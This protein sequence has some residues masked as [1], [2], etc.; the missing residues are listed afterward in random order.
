MIVAQ[1][2]IPLLITSLSANTGII[3]DGFGNLPILLLPGMDG[4]NSR[5]SESDASP[6]LGSE[7]VSN[8]GRWIPATSR[9]SGGAHWFSSADATS[10]GKRR[11]S[12]PLGA[13]VAPNIT[14]FSGA[15]GS[16]FTVDGYSAQAQNANRPWSLTK[17]NA[18]TLQFSVRSGDHWS[19]GSYS[20]LTMNGGANRSEIQFSPLYAEGTQINMSETITVHPGPTNTASWLVLTQLHA[21]TNVAPTYSPFV[22]GLDTSDHLVVILQSPNQSWNNLVYRSP[23]PIVRGQPMN[24][25]FQLIMGPSGGG[26][27]GVWLD[28][29]Q[30]VNYHGPVGATNSEYYWKIGVY[31]G[32]ATETIVVDYQGL[33]ITTPSKSSPQ[34]HR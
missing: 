33:Q 28:G 18:N 7:T 14:S 31:R 5:V 26:Y 2:I 23:N 17:P 22:V 12:P 20:D 11:A 13:T 3:G 9:L 30:I 15:N 25:N 21:T 27:V 34:P 24:L 8:S 10:E 19:V 29:A 32:P 1:V 4:A 16:I 6:P